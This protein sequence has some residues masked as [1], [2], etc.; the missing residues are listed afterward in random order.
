MSVESM[1]AQV[2]LQFYDSSVFTE[3]VKP[4]KENKE[5][6]PFIVRLLTLYHTN[7]EV[8]KAVD[9][10]TGG[11]SVDMDED[12]DLMNDAFRDIQNIVMFNTYSYAEAMKDL[13]NGASRI[14]GTMDDVLKE[15]REQNPN[16]IYPEC[17][18]T[19]YGKVVSLNIPHF[20]EDNEKSKN[21]EPTE[22]V[23]SFIT[24]EDFDKLSSSID[25][26]LNS[27]E[28]LLR[29]FVS[30]GSQVSS[31]IGDRAKSSMETTRSE[32]PSTSTNEEVKNNESFSDT[33]K[34]ESIQDELQSSVPSEQEMNDGK[35]LMNEFLSN[36]I[37]LFT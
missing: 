31:N 18:D 36:N 34:D 14:Q 19:P 29:N 23:G 9:G 22:N 25:E 27:F 6:S 28:E 8:K 37:G 5:L 35:A 24:H 21:S 15:Q 10:A 4:K 12:D 33:V 11:V 26:R 16:G 13:E 20:E 32:V 2:S 7:E 3:L 30:G 1:R 17:K